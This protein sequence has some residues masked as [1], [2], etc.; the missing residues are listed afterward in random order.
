MDARE[1]SRNLQT[2]G[3]I[4][5]LLTPLY[6]TCFTDSLILGPFLTFAVFQRGWCVNEVARELEDPFWVDGNDISATD[7][8]CLF[9]SG[10]MVIDAALVVT[11]EWREGPAGL[12]SLTSDA[13]S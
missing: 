10:L 6:I 2:F 3:H 11:R 8:H 7:F 13:T 5:A 12:A 1:Y 4:S 9:I